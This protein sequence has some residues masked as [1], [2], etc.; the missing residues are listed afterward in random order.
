[1]S[2]RQPSAKRLLQAALIA[3]TSLAFSPAPSP[4]ASIAAFTSS[5]HAAFP[6]A[7]IDAPSTVIENPTS[8]GLLRSHLCTL[9]VTAVAADDTAIWMGTANAG[10]LRLDRATLARTRFTTADGLGGDAVIFL[11]AEDNGHIWAAT[12]DRNIIGRPR[13]VSRYDGTA[14]YT[15]GAADGL[16]AANV[17]AMAADPAGGVW[18]GFSGQVFRWDGAAWI[19]IGPN[20]GVPQ[21]AVT[22]LAAAPDGAMWIGAGSEI[23]RWDGARFQTIGPDQ[24][25][26][27]GQVNALAL[28]PGDAI[29][30]GLSNVTPG[31]TAPGLARFQ[32]GRWTLLTIADGLAGN[33]VRDIVVD[34]AG[35]VWVAHTWESASSGS[36][37]FVSVLEGGAWRWQRP[38][39]GNALPANQLIDL[40]L[41]PEGA[42]V[43]GTISGGASVHDGTSWQLYRDPEPSPYALV[44][45]AVEDGPGGAVWVGYAGIGG[46]EHVVGRL[47]GARWSAFGASAGV[48]L[49]ALAVQPRS[50]AFDSAGWPW[51]A[52]QHRD[53]RRDV[54][55][56]DG[57]RWRSLSPL[58]GLPPYDVLDIAF[59]RQG[60]AWLALQGGVARQDGA[61]W[62]RFT[63]R[64]GLPGEGVRAIAVAP[65]GA[66]WAGTVSGAARFD[67][68]QWQAFRTADGLPDDT[69]LDIAFAPDGAVWLA[70]YRGLARFDGTAWTAHTTIAGIRNAFVEAVAVDRQGRVWAAVVSPGKGRELGLARFDGAAW[71][72]LT[73][74]DGLIHDAIYDVTV[75]DDGRVWIAT[76]YGLNELVPPDAGPPPPAPP[77]ECI[78]RVARRALPAAV[79]ADALANPNGYS[80]WRELANPNR[81]PG[82]TNPPRTCLD[83]QNPGTPF[84]PLFNAP[85]WRAN[86]R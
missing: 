27:R 80:G 3:A 53:F 51:A 75:G 47:D 70:T 85:V 68:R 59:D 12:R 43:A 28:G 1:M 10:V 18:I 41:T 52:I 24:G 4:A 36:G 26:P 33:L 31:L 25:M 6:A 71:T 21:G 39:P 72:H 78:C 22:A 44:P 50:L 8:L 54:I 14:W 40:A 13:G 73:V 60:R 19:S 38:E 82:P 49:D 16:P 81:P 2:R 7:S 76:L 29:W 15:F 63:S 11:V 42:V 45:Q 84:H 86:C 64:D 67:G 5:S 56:Y 57:V 83:I 32:N 61:T 66:V 55:R 37:H 34:D 9:C 20:L 74:A 48:P 79:L 58:D 35:R 17:Q 46:T 77:G 23:G 62:T 69:V 65:D 30:V